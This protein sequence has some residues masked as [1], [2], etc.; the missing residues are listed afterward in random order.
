MHGFLKLRRFNEN[1]R[2]ADRVPAVLLFHVSLRISVKK[3]SRKK[4]SRKKDSRKKDSC[5]KDSRK[6]D[7]CKKRFLK[8]SLFFLS[9]GL[10]ESL[11]LREGRVALVVA[12]VAGDD[13]GIFRAEHAQHH[14][15][16]RLD[17]RV[18]VGRDGA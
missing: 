1:G 6:K 17:A 8:K 11:G 12:A 18:D 4:D 9:Q 7:S 10:S 13:A 3:D 14:L 15:V 5:K 16:L 2:T